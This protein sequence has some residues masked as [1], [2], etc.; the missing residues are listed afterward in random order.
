MNISGDHQF[1]FVTFRRVSIEAVPLRRLLRGVGAAGLVLLL[2]FGFDRD[3]LVPLLSCVFCLAFPEL[4][5]LV[6]WLPQRHQASQVTR[7]DL[8]ET[9]VRV[10]TPSSDVHLT[11]VGMTRVRSHRHAWLLRH[12]VTQL[13]V[14]RAAFRPEDQ[15]TIDAFLADR[16]TKVPT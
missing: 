1:T 3:T 11:W 2:V 13:P 16:P 5:A 4:I 6:S 9:G 7:Y 8:D 10:R 14:P 15:V 12:G